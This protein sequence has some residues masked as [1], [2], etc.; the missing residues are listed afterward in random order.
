MAGLNQTNLV[1]EIWSKRVER[2]LID[3]K[4]LDKI[5]LVNTGIVMS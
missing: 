1:R 2:A 5:F 4:A 3:Q